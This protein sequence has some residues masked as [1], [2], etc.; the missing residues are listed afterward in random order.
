MLFLI[1]LLLL[2]FRG[3]PLDCVYFDQ[4]CECVHVVRCFDSIRDCSALFFFF[5]FVVVL[6][7]RLLLIICAFVVHSVR[8]LI[9]F[10]SVGM[11]AASLLRND[12]NYLS[13]RCRY[14]YLFGKSVDVDAFYLNGVSYQIP[15][16][17][18][19]LV[20]QQTNFRIPLINYSHTH[21]TSMRLRYLSK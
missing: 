14:L 11:A 15:M 7:L 20:G 17:A 6:L 10:F 1:L 9:D 5:S 16:F 18:H 8:Q 13:R 4:L 12:T 19:N 3:R 21:K 2:S